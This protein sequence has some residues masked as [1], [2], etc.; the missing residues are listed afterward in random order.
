MPQDATA[1]MLDQLL[2]VV[3]MTTIQAIIYGIV[4]YVVLRLAA[5]KEHY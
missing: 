4:G 5:R 1:A 2:R 3:L